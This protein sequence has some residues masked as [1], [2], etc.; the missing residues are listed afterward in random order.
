[1][2]RSLIFEY[3]AFTAHFY[4]FFRIML[5]FQSFPNTHDRIKQPKPIIRIQTR[6]IQTSQVATSVTSAFPHAIHFP[7]FIIVFFHLERLFIE[8][9]RSAEGVWR[10]CLHSST[11]CLSDIRIICV[12]YLPCGF[13]M[14]HDCLCRVCLMT[15]YEK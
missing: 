10:L 13:E 14:C 9:R 12:Q 8:S 5:P 7:P 3:N 2:W 11:I 1:M 4:F 15:K 6:D